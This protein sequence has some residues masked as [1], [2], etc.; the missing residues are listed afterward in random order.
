MLKLSKYIERHSTEGKDLMDAF[1]EHLNTVLVDTFRCV[2]KV[3]EKALRRTSKLDLSI[4][5][6]HLVEAVGRCGEEGRTISGIAKELDITLPSVT[7]AINKLMKKG[8]VQKCRCRTDGRSVRVT[9]TR[10]GQKAHAAHGY[11][12]RSLVRS[13]A[14][15]LTREEKSA[16]IKGMIKLNEFF[17]QKLNDMED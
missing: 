8:F 10:L 7:V 3:E 4:S 2:L 6:L 9:L 16:M 11:F 17:K 14:K 12:H 13:V 15:E 5:E 1:R